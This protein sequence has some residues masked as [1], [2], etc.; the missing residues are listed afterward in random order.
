[1]NKKKIVIGCLGGILAG[2]LLFNI[3]FRIGT[4]SVKS[5]IVPCIPNSFTTKS[6]LDFQIP[7][8]EKK[9]E[10]PAPS[11][12]EEK[13]E[14]TKE[15]TNNNNKKSSSNNNNKKKTTTTTTI[16][17]TT[18]KEVESEHNHT[19]APSGYKSLGTFKITAYCSCKK[20]TGSGNGITA[21]GK[22]ATANHTIAAPKTFAFGTILKINGIE[23]T[24]EDRGGAIKGN[25][26]DVYFNSHQEALNWGVKYYEVF[27][28]I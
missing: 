19:E 22:K 18:V 6:L 2:C 7:T 5:N 25:R 3:G 9:E 11:K 8:E 12:T 21:S 4:K 26:L 27:Q 14:T 13:K 10:D 16:K 28:K 24:V 23:Y 17:E 15:V 1:M 20:C